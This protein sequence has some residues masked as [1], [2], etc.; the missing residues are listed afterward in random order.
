MIQPQLSVRNGIIPLSDLVLEGHFGNHL[1]MPMVRGV[2]Y[3]CF[4]S[5]ARMP[6]CLFR[7]LVR[8]LAG[9]RV[10][11]TAANLTRRTSR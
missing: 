1:A 4:L 8:M 2:G 6:L 7:M 9:D 11:R 3:S 10:A 5:C